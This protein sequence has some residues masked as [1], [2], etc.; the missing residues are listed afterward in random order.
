MMNTER[1]LARVFDVP[2]AV[3]DSNRPVLTM[4]QMVRSQGHDPLEIDEFRI[5]AALAYD[6]LIRLL[7]GGKADHLFVGISEPTGPELVKGYF[8][9]PAR[10][11]GEPILEHGIAAIVD[12][13]RANG[14]EDDS[15][16]Q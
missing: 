15:G 9:A 11:L 1:L 16:W 12:Y 3:T 6:E 10:G 5:K 4:W 2:Y 13:V 14:F 8:S 7:R